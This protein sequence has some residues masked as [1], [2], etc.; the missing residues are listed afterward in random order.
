M[1]YENLSRKRL[2]PETRHL[3]PDCRTEGG[4]QVSGGSGSGDKRA[5]QK[6]EK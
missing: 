1:G 3:F 6:T 2:T 5:G 4:D